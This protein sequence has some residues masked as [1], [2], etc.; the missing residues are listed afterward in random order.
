MFIDIRMSCKL[1]GKVQMN[2]AA[3]FDMQQLSPSMPGNRPLGQANTWC[4]SSFIL[5]GS[6]LLPSM[7]FRFTH[8]SKPLNPA[9]THEA[10]GFGCAVF[11]AGKKHVYYIY[12]LSHAANLK[13]VFS[14]FGGL[15]VQH[16]RGGRCR[17]VQD[18]KRNCRRHRDSDQD[19]W[20]AA[21]A[22][23]TS[24]FES[25]EY[26]FPNQ[27]DQ[28]VKNK[29]TNIQIQLRPYSISGNGQDMRAGWQLAGYHTCDDL[30]PDVT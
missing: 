16:A 14:R 11:F 17:S 7:R 18:S 10:K 25:L 15:F 4:D 5:F 27:S 9:A 30:L 2:M 19:F 22:W 3:S 13:R 8:W 20:T 6:I 12:I 29:Y 1:T 21:R 26:G 24:C 23:A 28:S